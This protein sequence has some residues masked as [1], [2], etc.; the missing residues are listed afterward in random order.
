MGTRCRGIPTRAGTGYVVLHI[1][2]LRVSPP[3]GFQRLAELGTGIAF[4]S[5]RQRAKGLDKCPRGGER[6]Y[7]ADG[8]R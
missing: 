1:E 6:R 4:L 7:R 2:P 5:R 3:S 8:P